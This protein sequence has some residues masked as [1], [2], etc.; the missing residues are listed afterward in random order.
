MEKSR[1]ERHCPEVRITGNDEDGKNYV[2]DV[3]E[4]DLWSFPTGVPH[5][6]QGGP[7]GA[8]Y[9]LVFDDGNFDASG[10][11]FMVDDW[12]AHT[13]REVLVQNFGWNSSVFDSIPATDPYI[14]PANDW[15]S[16]DEAQK[17]VNQNPNGELE[18]PYYYALSKQDA[19]QAPGGGGWTK[20]TDYR[21]FAS[22]PTLASA[23]VHV[24]VGALRELHW[25]STSEWGYVIKG[26][27]RAT[28]FAGGS[29]ARTFELQAGDSWTFP[30]K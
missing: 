9:L 22:S 10:T 7:E 12:I 24:D 13:P 30:T 3:E 1:S 23:L 2:A 25:H 16:L 5:S 26:K 28:A 15:P 17:A 27:G 14:I 11:T 20:I 21:Q 18:N 6:L 19:V 4:G 29:T 8:E